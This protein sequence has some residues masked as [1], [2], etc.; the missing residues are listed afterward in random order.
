MHKSFHCDT[1]IRVLNFKGVSVD[2]VEDVN[3]VLFGSNS[4]FP[5]P[6]AHQLKHWQWQP[7]LYLSLSLSFLYLAGEIYLR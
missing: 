6:P 1:L 7:P 3:V 2:T 5:P 4:P